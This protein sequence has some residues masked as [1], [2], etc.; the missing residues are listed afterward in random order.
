[1]GKLIRRRAKD[2]KLVDKDVKTSTK[3][4]IN[5]KVEPRKTNLTVFPGKANKKEDTQIDPERIKAL[6]KWRDEELQDYKVSIPDSTVK[7]PSYMKIAQALID[8]DGFIMKAAIA[9]KITY[10]KLNKLI[11][12][13]PK[14]KEIVIDCTEAFVDL[15]ENK[16]KDA[17]LAGNL[18]AVIFALKCKGASRGWRD[19]GA[20]IVSDEKPVAFSYNLRLPVGCRLVTDEGVE[21][22]K[23]ESR[24]VEEMKKEVSNG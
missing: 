13:N 20:S 19:E 8:C 23:D 17:V 6:K 9:L 16:L 24:K 4:I 11:K 7:N 18:T 3:E 5:M 15:A 1:M 22:Y 14:L 12:L 2:I 21:V 10:R